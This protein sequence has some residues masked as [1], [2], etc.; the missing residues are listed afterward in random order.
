MP[1]LASHYHDPTT[2]WGSTGFGSAVAQGMFLANLFDM[3]GNIWL[4]T[5]NR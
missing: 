4:T 5:L 2:Q 1:F 3:S